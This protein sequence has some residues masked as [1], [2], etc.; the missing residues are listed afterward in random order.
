M[1]DINTNHIVSFAAAL[2]YYF[3]MAFF[4]ALIT[5]A[6]IVAYLPIP[7]LF[8]TIVSTLASVAPPESIGLIRRIAADVI[9]PSRGA[10]L[11]FRPYRHALDLLQRLRRDY[12]SPQRRLRC[13][14]NPA[15]LEDAL[16]GARTPVPQRNAGDA[17]VRVP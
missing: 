17:G 11:S 2:S 6:A 13:S 5:L 16:A 3:V 8:D 7:D 15:V 9:T 10:L 12:R 1:Q 14:G 4:P